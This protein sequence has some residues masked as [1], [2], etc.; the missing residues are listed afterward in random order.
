MV[1]GS[2][3]LKAHPRSRG[4]NVSA[5]P[6]ATA[7]RWL[8]PA[9]AGKT[10]RC[11][12]SF[13]PGRAHPRSRGENANFL[14]GVVSSPGSSP[15]TRGKQGELA[16]TTVG[17]GLIPA[18]AGKTPGRRLVCVPGA[19]HPRSRG[20]NLGRCTC[21]LLRRGSSPLTRGKLDVGDVQP[22]RGGLIPAHAGKTFLPAV[23]SEAVGA[24]P[25][26]RGENAYQSR[27]RDIFKGSSPLTRGKT[28]GKLGDL[29]PGGLIPA[30]AGKTASR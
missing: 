2:R 25:R 18:H 11:F 27:A 5:L 21:A 16:G 28:G 29:C 4:E 19:A 12:C 20:E 1:A 7:L 8:I 6:P 30:H 15:L 13:C 26:S 22:P 10:F 9:H 14:G 24:H 3:P 17:G 23:I